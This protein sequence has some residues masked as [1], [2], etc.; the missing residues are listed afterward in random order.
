MSV[1]IIFSSLSLIGA[2][3]SFMFA[4]KVKMYSKAVNEIKLIDR[5][6]EDMQKYIDSSED[7]EISRSIIRKEI[8]YNITDKLIEKAI[9][10]LYKENAIELKEEGEIRSYKDIDDKLFICLKCFSTIVF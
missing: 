10:Q 3:V 8:S 9:F 4:R 1:D 2:F 5:L 7:K 6:K